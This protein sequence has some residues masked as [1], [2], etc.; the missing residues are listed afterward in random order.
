MMH[1]PVR[2]CRGWTAACHRSLTLGRE[3]PAVRPCELAC[4]RAVG[5]LR[6]GCTG[7][8]DGVVVALAAEW[9]ATAAGWGTSPATVWVPGA[10]M[11]AATWLLGVAWY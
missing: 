5:R 10:V 6:R 4:K 1:Y 7:A 8:R 2:S 3:R 11:G 9:L